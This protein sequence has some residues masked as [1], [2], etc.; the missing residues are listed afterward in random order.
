MK[1]N[2]LDF[3][4]QIATSEDVRRIHD[5]ELLSYTL[6]WSEASILAWIEGTDRVYFLARD[7][8][9]SAVLGYIAVFFV[10]GEGE[11]ASVAVHPNER[12]KGVAREIFSVIKKYCIR[13]RIR[14]LFLEVREN[15]IAAIS[16]YKS[17]G[18]MDVGRRKG[19]YEDT[20]E[21]AILMRFSV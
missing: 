12:R 15:N 5:I 4:I 14:T 17:L 2:P 8:I 21:D 10:A 18:F 1:K 19:Y 6:P 11:I 13:E 16:L 7:K 9:T 20:K 3:S